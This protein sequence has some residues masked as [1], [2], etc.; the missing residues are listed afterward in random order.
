MYLYPANSATKYTLDHKEII[1]IGEEHIK[2]VNVKNNNDI[3]TWDFL[4]NKIQE[5][6]HVNLEL[7]ENFKNHLDYVI[8][9]I[10]SISIKQFLIE[11]KKHRL[12]NRVSGIDI[13]R[14]NKFFG[15]FRDL[16]TQAHFFNI[17]RELTNVDAKKILHIITN[18]SMFVNNYFFKNKEHGGVREIVLKINP[19][20]MEQIK[21]IHYQS[22]LHSQFL[23][24]LMT[25]N[26]PY[27]FREIGSIMKNIKYDKNIRQ[28]VEDFRL[29]I[30][31]FVDMQ[32]FLMMLFHNNNKQILLIGESHARD[33]QY[34]FNRYITYPLKNTT[35][36]INQRELNMLGKEM[37]NSGKVYIKYLK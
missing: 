27:L 12:M 9:S 24:S 37:R 2:N 6:Y 20:F 21:D 36:K 15:I 32:I 14:N 13:R 18:V 5:G 33:M 10:D 3:Y 34:F 16:N 17:T 11:A 35:S 28:I 19:N 31:Y 1:I 8:D 25:E 30:L 26:R 22:H 29:F 4:L 7:A 23:Y